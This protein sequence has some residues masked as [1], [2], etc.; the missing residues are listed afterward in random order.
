[1]KKLLLGTTLLLTVLVGHDRPA[2]AQMSEGCA[3]TTLDSAASAC[4]S[5]PNMS[6][7]SREDYQAIESARTRAIDLPLEHDPWGQALV[8]GAFGGVI[9]GVGSAI[10]GSSVASGAIAGGLKDGLTDLG[11]GAIEGMWEHNQSQPIGGF[12]TGGAQGA[13]GVGGFEGAGGYGNGG[14]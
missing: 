8:G 10:A 7:F 1:M 6:T 2:M 9:G 13:G 4:E 5:T 12:N 3:P 11:M 14:Y